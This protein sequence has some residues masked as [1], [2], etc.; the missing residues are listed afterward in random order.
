MEVGWWAGTAPVKTARAEAPRP[1][2]AGTN[3]AALT[4]SCTSNYI[5]VTS[6]TVQIQ[7]SAV[8]PGTHIYDFAL[9]VAT[10]SSQAV[11][12]MISVT[13]TAYTLGKPVTVYILD[14]TS[15]NPPDCYTSICRRLD[16]VVLYP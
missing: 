4:M 1:P 12:R 11:N 6:T 10:A 5:H 2:L 8:Y 14:D 15:L 9:P 13:T 7:C 16:G 3:A